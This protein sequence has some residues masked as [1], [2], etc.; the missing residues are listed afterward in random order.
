MPKKMTIKKANF[1]DPDNQGVGIN[2]PVELVAEADCIVLMGLGLGVKL[3]EN[4]SCVLTATTV[5]HHPFQVIYLRDV[6]CE[7]MIAEEKVAMVEREAGGG[8]ALMSG[9]TTLLNAAAAGPTGDIHVP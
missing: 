4:E 3:K 2:D 5:G 1:I 9:T 6:E 8:V 7:P